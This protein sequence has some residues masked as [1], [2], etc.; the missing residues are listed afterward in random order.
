[1]YILGSPHLRDEPSLEEFIVII[2]SRRIC[3][4][5]FGT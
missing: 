4:H 2:G 5:P 1:M 3:A